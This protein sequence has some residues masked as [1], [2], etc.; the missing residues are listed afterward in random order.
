MVPVARNDAEPDDSAPAACLASPA[1]PACRAAARPSH[2]TPVEVDQSASLPQAPPLPG[3]AAI[4]SNVHDAQPPAT[5]AA[6]ALP[7]QPCFSASAA[8]ASRFAPFM[9]GIYSSCP[10]S[11]RG[12]PESARA[13][14]GSGQMNPPPKTSTTTNVGP[15][16]NTGTITQTNCMRTRIQ[17]LVVALIRILLVGHFNMHMNANTKIQIL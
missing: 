16:A 11:L 10:L 5:A 3:T 1:M 8:S 15:C 12:D 17:M 4:T 7:A 6:R 2:T 9:T 14:F 13:M